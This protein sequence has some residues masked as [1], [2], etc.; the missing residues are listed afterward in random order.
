[1]AKNAEKISEKAYDLAMKNLSSF[2]RPASAVDV[3]EFIPTGHLQLDIAITQ[4][5]DPESDIDFNELN[6][7]ERGFPLGKLVEI[8]GQEGSG[9]SS[10]AYRVVGYAQK[11]GYKCGWIDSE[12]SF[13]PSLAEIN[14]VDK[15]A[16]AFADLKDIEE[17]DHL[18]SAE[19]VFDRICDMCVGGY[20][21][22]VLDSVANLS[23]KAEL[24]NYLADGGVGMGA[25][26]QA[27]SK[28][29]KKI[30]NYAAKY[31]VLVIMINQIR[32]KIGVLFGNPETTPGGRALKFL[33]SVRIKLQRQFGEKGLI[34]TEVETDAGTK[35]ESIGGYA[36]VYILK[37]RFAKPVQNA[38]RIPVYYVKYFPGIEEIIFNEGRRLKV[39]GKHLKTFRWDDIKEE[40]KEKFLT[41]VKENNRIME[42]IAELKEAATTQ[43]EILAPEVLYYDAD[44]AEFE[45][46]TIVVKD[47][48]EEKVKSDDNKVRGRRKGKNPKSVSTDPLE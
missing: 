30:I 42:L 3:P 19:E 8:S 10:L 24:D 34:E 27:L 17:P 18:Y 45:T 21:V 48:V 22:I 33:S 5:I 26:A 40:G 13:S 6:L 35:K 43:K 23:T 25:L 46:G 44:E 36:Y 37:N 7:E 2:L 14:G 31:N 28:G 12:Q 4:G 11:K 41:S 15:T 1:M 38:A 47:E 32:E 39:I 16:L 29:L 9:K 20:K